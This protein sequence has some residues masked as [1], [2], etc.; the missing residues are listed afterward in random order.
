MQSSRRRTTNCSL[1]S[2]YSSTTAC[3]NSRPGRPAMRTH[4]PNI[5]R[6]IGRKYV[7]T[8]VTVTYVD[9]DKDQLERTIRLLALTSLAF[10]NI[11]QE[12]PYSTIAAT[13]DIESSQVERWVID[14]T[15]LS[16]IDHKALLSSHVISQSSVLAWSPAASH[17]KHRPCTSRARLR[18][19]SSVRSGS[20]SSS[21]Y[22][23]GRRA[24][25]ACSRSPPSH[26]DGAARRPSQT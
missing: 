3:P 4:L 19:R 21:V 5:V 7:R 14:G 22:R 16:P 10:Q 1:C 20:S 8:K 23:L 17:R 18:A 25:R 15:V 6:T 2:G 13:I 26:S 24:L 11:G 12:L 9:L